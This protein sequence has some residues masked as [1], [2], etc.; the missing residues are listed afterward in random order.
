MHRCAFS[1]VDLCF[2]RSPAKS[3]RRTGRGT[4][5]SLYYKDPGSYELSLRR[6]HLGLLLLQRP[7]ERAGP[8]REVC[9]GSSG[10]YVLSVCSKRARFRQA[11]RELKRNRAVCLHKL[12]SWSSSSRN[13]RQTT[14]RR[15]CMVSGAVHTRFFEK[16]RKLPPEPI[17]RCLVFSQYEI[18]T[19]T[20]C[21]SSLGRKSP[22]S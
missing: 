13:R 15:H 16:Q 21:L 20:R 14:I 12:P 3:G 22:P 4:T 18:H 1:L 5:N 17:A 11:Y 6:S 10:S 19:R 8:L 2:D 7:R 9:R